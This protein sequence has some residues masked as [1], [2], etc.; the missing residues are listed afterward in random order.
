MVNIYIRSGY[1]LIE[2]G[3]KFVSKVVDETISK[4]VNIRLK[5]GDFYF[6]RGFYFKSDFHRRFCGISRPRTFY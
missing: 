2:K 3:C 1:F 6:K 5:N 4:A